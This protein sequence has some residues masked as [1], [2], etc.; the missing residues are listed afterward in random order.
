MI[1]YS[2]RARIVGDVPEAMAWARE[3]NLLVGRIG[4]VN[5]E[6]ALRVGAGLD[7]LWTARHETMAVLET[8]LDTWQS[9]A[10]YQSM[11]RTAAAK[12]L[13]DTGSI[14]SAIWR[15]I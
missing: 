5:G 6:V 9:N 13:F 15:T 2:T 10:E 14:E 8:W 11:I 4:G 3:I 7:V 12:G 1:F